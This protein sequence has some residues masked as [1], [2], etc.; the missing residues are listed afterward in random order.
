MWFW[1]FHLT[2]SFNVF[3]SFE[4]QSSFFGFAHAWRFTVTGLH[5]LN[6]LRL[7]PYR[8]LVFNAATDWSLHSSWTCK[9]S[10]ISFRL[11]LSFRKY[12]R[13]QIIERLIVFIH[14]RHQIL[15]L[16]IQRRL[17]KI[18]T[19]NRIQQLRWRKLPLLIVISLVAL[20]THILGKRII[21]TL[22]YSW[23][24]HTRIHL[25]NCSFF[26]RWDLVIMLSD[27]V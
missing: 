22:I 12:R 7:T 14:R 20:D 8:S 17:L 2:F 19:W 21:S 10:L 1:F 5:E 6:F 27:A 13:L 24:I 9:R 25:V 11:S 18:Q 3:K 26:S 15:K 23:D 4:F 16:I